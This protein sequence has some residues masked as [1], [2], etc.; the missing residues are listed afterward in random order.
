MSNFLDVALVLLLAVV[1]GYAGGWAAVR[2]IVANLKEMPGADQRE[3]L[4]NVERRD[5]QGPPRR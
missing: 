4:D 5:E 3:Y 2:G 1:A